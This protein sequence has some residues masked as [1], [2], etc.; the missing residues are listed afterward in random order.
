MT[1]MASAAPDRGGPLRRWFRTARTA[2]WLGWQIESN[3]TEPFQFFVYSIA[4]PLGGALILVFMYYVVA[5]ADRGPIVDYFIVGS[6]FWPFVVSGMQGMAQGI[7][8]DREH[9]RTLRYIYTAPIPYDAYLI[10]RALAHLAA[11]AFAMAVTLALGHLALGVSFVGV[12]PWLL[13]LG[14]VCGLVAIIA[15]GLLLVTLAMSVSGDAWRMPEGVGAA[16][17]LLS[18]VIF[19][20]TVLPGALQWLARAFPLTWWLEVVRRGLVGSMKVSSF[21]TLTDAQVAIGLALTTVVYAGLAVVAFQFGIRRARQLGI[22][23]Q[24]S[25]Y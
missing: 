16:L 11:A 9:W 19:P 17:Y 22:L 14:A 7:I 10:G 18:G 21:P 6:A 8:S 15:L 23:D 12:Q 25:A 4:R 5:R 1:T 2:F 3:W 24:E 13:V 20:I